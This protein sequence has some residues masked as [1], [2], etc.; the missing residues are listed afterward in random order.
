[1]QAAQLFHRFFGSLYGG[2]TDAQLR[3]YLF[4]VGFSGMGLILIPVLGTLY[5][6]EGIYWLALINSLMLAGIVGNLVFLHKTR[7]IN[8]SENIVLAVLFIVLMKGVFASIDQ[9]GPYW[10]ALFPAAAFFIKG[11]KTGGVLVSLMVLLLFAF[12]AAQHANWLMTDHS[13]T[14]LIFLGFSLLTLGSILG[15]SR[16]IL[17]DAEERL[18]KRSAELS[19]EVLE[20]HSVEAMLRKTEEQMRFMAHRDPLTGLP[21]RALGFDR[22]E[23]TLLYAERHRIGAAVILL[24]IDDFGLL[25]RQ[26]GYET[27]DKVLKAVSQRLQKRLRRC[28]T[29]ARAGIDEFMIIFSD[30]DVGTALAKLKIGLQEALKDP[31]EVDGHSF[32]LTASIGAAAFPEDGD[33]PEILIE[34]ADNRLFTN[35]QQ[36]AQ[37]KTTPSN[38]PANTPSPVGAE[39]MRYATGSLDVG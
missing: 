26:H 12:A 17:A 37:E 5:I 23:Q 3:Q 18:S 28:D 30:A 31:F 22:L 4:V 16:A 25:N 34:A 21:N 27:G 15:V 36:R 32:D 39:R 9:T 2:V 19:R 11:V 1:M 7:R 13:T 38:I 35:Q 14:A 6:I 33:L 10:F 8:A 20:R 24:D 29:V